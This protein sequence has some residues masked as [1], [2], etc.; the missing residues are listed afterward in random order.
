MLNKAMFKSF[1]RYVQSFVF[2]SVLLKNIKIQV[3]VKI[4][5]KK[6]V[7]I[8]P[9]RVQNKPKTYSLLDSADLNL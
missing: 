3:S 2:Y 6:S 4:T 8:K 1:C 7:Q 5:D 9:K